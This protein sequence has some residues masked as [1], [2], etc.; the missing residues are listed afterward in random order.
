MA[1]L[2]CFGQD[3]N[4]RYQA[5]MIENQKVSKKVTIVLMNFLKNAGNNAVE[6]M[7]PFCRALPLLDCLVYRV[8]IFR[9]FQ[10]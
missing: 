6:A 3:V 9:A 2:G 7:Q 5:L 8:D 1:V 4:N 10:L